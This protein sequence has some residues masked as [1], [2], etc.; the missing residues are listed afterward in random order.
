MPGCITRNTKGGQLLLPEVKPGGIRSEISMKFSLSKI[1]EEFLRLDKITALDTRIISLRMSGTLINSMDRIQYKEI[2]IDGGVKYFPRAISFQSTLLEADEEIF[3]LTVDGAYATVMA[4]IKD[5]AKHEYGDEAWNWAWGVLR[6]KNA[7][8][9]ACS[10]SGRSSAV[11]YSATPK[12]LPIDA[13]LNIAVAWM[14]AD[15]N[16]PPLVATAVEIIAGPARI[17]FCRLV[18]T[19]WVADAAFAAILDGLNH[20]SLEGKKHIMVGSSWRRV[21][22]LLCGSRRPDNK[23]ESEAI[24][25]IAQLCRERGFILSYNHIPLLRARSLSLAAAKECY[26]ALMEAKTSSGEDCLWSPDW[27]EPHMEMPLPL[28]PVVGETVA[29]SISKLNTA[30]SRTL[31]M[32]TELRLGGADGFSGID[33]EDCLA[34]IEKRF[35]AKTMRFAAM[36]SESLFNDDSDGKSYLRWVARGL[37]PPIAFEKVWVDR[38]TNMHFNLERTRRG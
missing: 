33:R 14:G 17:D 12:S 15:K 28:V 8:H 1:R 32:L 25:S 6:D 30:E 36:A 13:E 19:A 34:V 26:S 31:R 4:V 7:I 21:Y 20:P 2:P 9:K 22:E 29:E 11:P 24:G 18:Q 23:Y 27:I 35:G 3:Y 38:L 10:G 16:K 37:L 5:G